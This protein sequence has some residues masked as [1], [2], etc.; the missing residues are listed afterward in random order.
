MRAT[1]KP[2]RLL[3][4]IIAMVCGILVLRAGEPPRGNAESRQSLRRAITDLTETLG[5]RYP[6]GKEWL[7]R[8]N[9]LDNRM[10][11]LE[12]AGKVEAIQEYRKG[13]ETLRRE[14]LV[15]NPL[16][17][18]QPILFVVR[19]QY[20]EDHHDTETMFQSDE[21]A[22]SSFRGGGALT[23]VDFSAAG[24]V[25]TLLET[26]DGVIR[27][28]D[29]YFDG[30]K[31]IFSMRKNSKDDYHLYEIN[32]NGS[33]LRQLTSAP[34]VFDI[35]PLYLPDDS[36]VFTS[37]REPKYC[38]CN[39]HV[40][41]NLF[42]MNPDCSNIHQISKNT[43]FDGHASL[44][45]DGRILY[46]RWEY[47]DRNYG[48]AQ[49]LWTCHPD[50]TAHTLYWKNNTA[51]PEAMIHPRA[52]CGTE[53]AVGI[54]ATLH[55][56]F[57]A[58]ALIDRGLGMDGRVPVLQT[59]PPEAMD[60][61]DLKRQQ[62]LLFRKITERYQDP[63]PLFD[64][65]A[66]SLSGKFFLCSRL[67]PAGTSWG[68]YL[69]DVF[70]NEIPLVAELPGCFDPTPLGPKP[71]PPVLPTTRDF[72]NECGSFYIHN[73]YEGTHMRGV[74]PGS[75]KSLRVVET[76]EKSFRTSS[77][78]WLGQGGM[79]P[80]MNW[81]DHCN[82]RIL[83]TVPVEAD[84][85]AYFEVPSE[86]FVYFQLLDENGMMIQ[87]M[88]SGT[89]VQSGEHAAC[90]GCHEER[91][92]APLASAVSLASRREPSNLNDWYGPPREFS[93]MAEVQPVLTRHCVSCHDYGQAAGRKLNL[94][95]DRTLTFNTAYTELWRKGYTGCIG[96]G[97]AEI[98]QAYSWGSHASKLVQELR[99]PKVAEH[100]DLKLAS[101]ELERIVTWIDLNGVYYPTYA[102]AYPESLT[103]R[104]P[105]DNDQLNRLNQLT[106]W[107]LAAQ[108][109]H[110]ESLGPEVSFERPELSPCLNKLDPGSTQYRE[111]LAIIR[112]GKETL[113]KRPRADMPGFQACSADQQREVKYQQR[114]QIELHVR[115]A[116]RQGDKVFDNSARD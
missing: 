86:R 88:R 93:F 32:A 108:K 90:T 84:G 4:L 33:G 100:K 17:S 61:I 13:L 70:G 7:A 35:D 56:Q 71:R 58:L 107:P 105:L 95:P 21:I 25:K 44:M 104:M 65:T 30:K 116:I 37:S 77:G 43:L 62:L 102:S 19:N 26:A 82:K 80:A 83:G 78:Y 28:P 15:A 72:N 41:G 3:L 14:A 63:Y 79:W 68:I 59:W 53:L 89:T 22:A 11:A 18:G 103:G 8:L 73:V 42:R 49:G 64:P 12:Q 76:P 52:V 67:T 92:A 96:A 5:D 27:D 66:A 38:M 24:A 9:S 74:K 115:Q 34:G 99:S 23:V 20:L 87:S 39:R 40:M 114:R 109:S 69:V 94:A 1:R 46:D 50:G 106:G 113:A 57:G 51:A 85:S 48:D 111:A 81:H 45:P 31:I 97:P 75:V 2:L 47:V 60:L 98:Q 112:A 101:E 16:V 110:S 54:F 29:V 55:D 91:R 6:H 10:C 36:I